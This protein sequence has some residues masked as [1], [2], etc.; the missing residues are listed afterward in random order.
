VIVALLGP[1]SVALPARLASLLP[2]GSTNCHRY[3]S[4]SPHENRHPTGLTQAQS[5]RRSACRARSSSWSCPPTRWCPTTSR[6][7]RRRR[8]WSKRL[9]HP[10]PRCSRSNHSVP[11]LNGGDGGGACQRRE[12]QIGG[13]DMGRDAVKPDRVAVV[14]PAAYPKSG[15]DAQFDWDIKCHFLG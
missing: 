10:L 3:A 2:V 7:S 15:Y 9:R 13:R 8:W 4:L 6:R 5:G 12:P 11:L 1:R 14:E